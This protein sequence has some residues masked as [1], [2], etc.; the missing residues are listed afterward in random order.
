M[1][2][3]ATLADVAGVDLRAL[4]AKRV[5]LGAAHASRLKRRP[6]GEAASFTLCR[7][8][9]M[10]HWFRHVAYLLLTSGRSTVCPLDV[11]PC[12]VNSML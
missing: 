2:V 9:M 12:I 10:L 4:D 1:P 5:D 3:E 7:S 6:L 11:M 8:V